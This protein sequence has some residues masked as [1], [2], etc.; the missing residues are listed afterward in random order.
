MGLFWLILCGLFIIIEL[1]TV[2]FLAFF[3]AIGAFL[4]SIAAYLNFN[5]NFQI[6][7][8]LVTSI[9]LIIFMKP[10]MNKA[11][12]TP[13]KKTNVNRIISKKGIV[14]ETINKFDGTG[15]VKI[16]GELWSALAENEEEIIEKD[17]K[18]E[19]LKIKGVKV[20]V[21]KI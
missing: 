14:T 1:C 12:K 19:V 8:F 5:P 21:K 20:I 6:I 16:D 9:L 3:P 17:T 11:I 7:I 18:I 2:S 15:I 10:I 4:A 13:T